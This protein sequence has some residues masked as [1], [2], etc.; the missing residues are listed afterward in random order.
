[1]LDPDY[2]DAIS[3]RAR[4]HIR[5]GD[6]GAAL[7]DTQ[8]LVDLAPDGAVLY[9]F[10]AVAKAMGGDTSGAV[11]DF[12][13][14][15][16][17]TADPEEID[18]ILEL[19]AE[20]VPREEP[21]RIDRSDAGFS[22]TLPSAWE[23]AY[24]GEVDPDYWYEAEVVGDVK[25]WYEERLDDGLL[26]ESRG[27]ALS[28]T[29]AQWCDLFDITELAV[30]SPPW[31]DLEDAE[32]S[33]QEWYAGDPANSGV[34]TAYLELP[35]GR[36]LSID[37]RWEGDMDVREYFFTDGERWLRLGCSTNGVVADDRW[38]VHR[39][40]PGVAAEGG[41]R[42]TRIARSLRHSEPRSMED[43]TMHSPMARI[44]IVL[45][46]SLLIV[47]VSGCSALSSLISG[48]TEEEAVGT[49]SPE[50]AADQP[51]TLEGIVDGTRVEL[52]GAAFAMT[53]PGD[54]SVETTDPGPDVVTAAPGDA[55]EV[56][57]AYGPERLEACSVSL[58]IAPEGQAP[59]GVSSGG[60]DAPRW[61]A[62][63]GELFLLVQ[64]PRLETESG[65]GMATI[66]PYERP[67]SSQPRLEHDVL[68]VVAC[69]TDPPRF[70]DAITESLEYLLSDG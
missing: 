17:M 54:W 57:H 64:P 28:A 11:D 34:E 29:T 68:Y 38:P 18:A 1:M 59:S 52:A 16:T 48:G 3:A 51:P 10:R 50:E 53:F 12:D 26:L 43:P 61:N 67:S 66:A 8:R 31:L 44:G 19:K 25:S 27:P 24:A 42:M 70:L 33:H 65:D 69:V 40:I 56:L 9:A 23:Y 30:L 5:Q 41:G 4:A 63:D 14:A 22:I 15:L 58:A 32:R 21:Q 37:S 49:L 35:Q 7:S 60:E 39:R 55:W 46:S 6:A 36:M 45:A 2:F 13:Q 47:S 62:D 20:A